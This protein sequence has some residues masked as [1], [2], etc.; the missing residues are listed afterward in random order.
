M[1]ARFL[2]HFM[3][4]IGPARRSKTLPAG[5]LW[6]I[7]LGLLLGSLA[8]CADNAMREARARRQAFLAG[9]VGQ[10]EADA[11][12]ALGLP[13][14]TYEVDGHRFLAYNQ[15]APF[16]DFSFGPPVAIC[17]TTVEIYQGKVQSAS[18]HGY[19]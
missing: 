15:P 3:P 1:A 16:S 2:R 19:C 8:A 7:V 5:F 14:Q 4:K 6:P 18:M 17:Q 9:L 10:T 13:Q 12:R 11:I